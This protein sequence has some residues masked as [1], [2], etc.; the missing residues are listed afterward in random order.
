MVVLFSVL[1]ACGSSESGDVQ[2]AEAEVFASASPTLVSLPDGRLVVEMEERLLAL[3]PGDPTSEPMV[4][5]PATDVGEVHAAVPTAGAILVLAS[6]GTFV[7]RGDAWVPTEL[8]SAFDGPILD[9]VRL[10]TPTGLGLGDLWVATATSLYRIVDGEA[11][12]LELDED[13]SNVQLAIAPRPEGPALWVLLSDRVLEVWRDRSGVV[14]SARLELEGMPTAI[15]GSAASAE[16]DVTGWLV[17]DGQLF[18]IG[19]D[20]LLVD[21]G[22]AVERLVTSPLA[23]E[24]W[25]FGPEGTRLYA[26]GAALAVGGVDVASD[27]TMTIATDGSLFVSEAT[28]RQL[29]PR[30]Q[31]SIGG[32]PDGSLLVRPQVFPIT[33]EGEPVIVAR[34]DG[35][36]VEPLADPLR[37][38]LDPTALGEGSHTLEIDV[39][40]DDGTLP[41]LE[42]RNFEVVTN[43]T[44]SEDVAPLYESYCSQCHGE[45]GPAV[46]RLDT[47]QN[48]QAIFEVVLANIEDGRMPLNNDPLT[49]REIAIV[50]AW[51]V[52][53][54]AE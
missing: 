35:N 6:G 38:E 4:I 23:D 2:P 20:R 27:A 24:V 37:V 10:P 15:G 12:T 48:W 14:R 40:Y 17:I 42:R 28:V 31:V 43:A 36:E 49:Q 29:S 8:A 53:G 22:F 3:E 50:Q 52:G 47:Q 44:W 11:Q 21:R 16:Q 39:T 18:S 1:G 51:E 54:F 7:L 41:V 34:V 13:L 30:R 45:D 46:T 33:A 26:D 5:G 19:R 25:A 32:A 9:A